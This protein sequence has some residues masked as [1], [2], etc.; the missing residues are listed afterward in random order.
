ML[1]TYMNKILRFV[2]KV[3]LFPRTLVQKDLV[4][5]SEILIKFLSNIC[6]IAEDVTNKLIVH[7]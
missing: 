6:G 5:V 2:L 3:A 4:N 1:I 7:L